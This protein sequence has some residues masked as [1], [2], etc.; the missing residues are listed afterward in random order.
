MA[1]QAAAGML[2]VRI[3]ATDIRLLLL[4]EEP[5]GLMP[6]PKGFAGC[7]GLVAPL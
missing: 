1:L 5:W 3:D 4:L 6:V 2:L 7:P